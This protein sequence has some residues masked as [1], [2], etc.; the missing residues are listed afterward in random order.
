MGTV[1]LTTEKLNDA[2]AGVYR[3]EGTLGAGG[4]ATVYDARDEK[5]QRN[6][7]IKVLHPSVANEVS[8]ERFLQEVRITAQFSHPGILGLIDSGTI[9]ADG[10]ELPY[11]VMPR[12]EGETLRTRLEREGTLTVENAV[13]ITRQVAEALAYAHA[14]EV[15]HRDI[16]PE[17]ILLVGNRVLV[18]DFGIARAVSSATSAGI[19]MEGT[20][21]LGRPT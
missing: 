18:A 4:M 16:K 9:A 8:A 10:T 2:F 3:V 14:R 21:M 11:Y 12:I 1:I 17:N 5:H 20:G 19:T 15:I 7:A 6:V 13:D